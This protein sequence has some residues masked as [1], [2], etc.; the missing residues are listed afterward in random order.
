MQQNQIQYQPY[1][2]SSVSDDEIDLREL[3]SAIWN[4]KWI[5]I[6]VTTIF[7]IA[8]VIYALKQPDIYKADALLAPADSSRSSGLSKMAGQLGGLAALAGVNLGG[9]ETSQASLA[10]Q[11]MKSRQFI[12]NFVNDHDL[13]VPLMATEGWDLSNNKLLINNRLYDEKNNQWLREAKGLR[14]EKPSNQ[15]AYE[16]FIKSVLDITQDKESGLYTISV[17]HY[18]PYIAKQ[19]VTWLVQDINKVMRERTIAETTQNLSYLNTQLEKT[20]V[21]DMKSTF[22]KLIEDQTKSLML[23]EV[24]EEFTFKVVDP[25]V[26]PEIKNQPKRALICVL[27]TIIGV[28]ISLGIVLLLFVL[29]NN[30]QKK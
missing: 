14:S 16:V 23:A 27:G 2:P 13:L 21:A 4:G 3:F 20:A 5:I 11:V 7:A 29:R 17:K 22:Y 30:N 15:E 10:I 8:S 19:W 9:A 26:V 24:Q 28:M 25:A 6:A 1:P 18:S 12:E